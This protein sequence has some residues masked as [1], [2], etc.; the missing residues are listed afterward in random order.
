[1]KKF[2]LFLCLFCIVSFGYSRQYGGFVKPGDKYTCKV[3]FNYSPIV[4]E[5]V[6]SPYTV[7]WNLVYGS[8]E[9]FSIEYTPDPFT[10]IIHTAPK[11]DHCGPAVNLTCKLE[12]YVYNSSGKF[13]YYDQFEVIVTYKDTSYEEWKK[14]KN[15]PKQ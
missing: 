12:A 13:V 1:M 2:I 14:N 6:P 5:N 4:F 11:I 3:G 9:A 8:S 15:E 10:A 7:K